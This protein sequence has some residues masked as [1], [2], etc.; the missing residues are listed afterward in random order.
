[1][2]EDI[3]TREQLKILLDSH[4]DNIESNLKLILRLDSL[5]E[6]QKINC[7]NIDKLCEKI[8]KQTESIIF[9]NSS[10]IGQLNGVSN[11]IVQN[12][13]SLKNN[14][15]VAFSLMGTII[16]GLLSLIGTLFAK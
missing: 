5:I 2:S 3:V 8:D 6:Y 13:S 15:Y 12:Q 1:M 11:I 16:L 7:Q 10:I 9:S 4:R 14:L